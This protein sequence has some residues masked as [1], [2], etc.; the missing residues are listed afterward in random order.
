MISNKEITTENTIKI[1]SV[2]NEIFVI[3]KEIIENVKIYDITG[4]TVYNQSVN[5]T[6][7]TISTNLPQGVYLVKVIIGGKEFVGKVVL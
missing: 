4:K 7:T 3:S 1:F 6:Q 5:S 2:S